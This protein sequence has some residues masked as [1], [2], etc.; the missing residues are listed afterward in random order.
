MIKIKTKL[1]KNSL[2]RD[3]ISNLDF[4]MNINKY[5]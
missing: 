1:K 3:A 5:L 2:Y 4:N